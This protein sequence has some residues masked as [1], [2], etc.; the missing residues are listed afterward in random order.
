MDES[1][2]ILRETV[3]AAKVGD[4]EKTGFAEA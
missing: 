1:I 2:Q 4:R 3:Q